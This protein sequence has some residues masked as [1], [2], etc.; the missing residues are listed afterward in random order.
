MWHKDSQNQE[1]NWTSWVASSYLN[2]SIVGN[3]KVC[4]IVW[5]LCED[6]GIFSE[7]M[8][9]DMDC[10]EL[11]PRQKETKVDGGQGQ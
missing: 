1:E 7:E 9:G 2:D 8:D 3:R 10:S 4:E 5:L 11:K 6:W